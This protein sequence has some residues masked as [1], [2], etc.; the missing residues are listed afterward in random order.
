M[1]FI[2]TMTTT[3]TGSQNSTQKELLEASSYVARCY[4]FIDLGTHQNPKFVK[5]DGSP[6]E[7]RKI[8]ITFEFPTEMRVFDETK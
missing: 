6:V 1:L 7:Q 3:A 8:R 2:I 4:S 5:K